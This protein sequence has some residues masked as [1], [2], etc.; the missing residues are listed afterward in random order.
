VV[1]II[2]DTLSDVPAGLEADLGLTLV[3]LNLHFG[4]KVYR[5][6]IDITIDE[7][8]RQLASKRAVHP[9]TSAPGPGVFINLFKKLSKETDAILCVM[10][11]GKMSAIGESASLARD[12]VKLPCRIE[13]VDSKMIAGSLMLA[14]VA[15]AEA[16]K[17]GKDLDAVMD[18][19]KDVLPRIQMR[20][21]FDTLEY[22]RRG[23]R[24][25]KASALLGSLLKFQPVLGLKDGELF[26]YARPRSRA[27]AL[28]LL[29]SFV[30][31]FPKVE[32]LAVED[33]ATPAE[34][35]A[36]AEKLGAL[37]PSVKILRGLASPVIGAHTGPHVIA[38]SVLEGKK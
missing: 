10:A 15:A 28:K 20:I 14:V 22:L 5:D 32:R 33:A 18:T 38:V 11:S 21:A 19:V 25:G 23:G 4:E 2:T 3:P 26:P 24:I 6:R 8:Y 9:T 16:A 37:F 35:D 27:L 30:Q 1:K 12:M 34:A 31:S 7:F 36:L 13:V 29:V 17:A